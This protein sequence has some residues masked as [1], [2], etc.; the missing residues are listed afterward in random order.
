MKNNKGF[1]L[2]ELLI[3]IAIIG[4]LGVTVVFSVIGL[5]NKTHNNTYE[6][7]LKDLLNA[8]STYS[9]LS[10][11]AFDNGESHPDCS[12]SCSFSLEALVHKGLVDKKIYETRSPIYKA[13]ANFKPSDM[14]YVT[15]INGEKD[16]S[17]RSGGCSEVKLSTIDTYKWEQC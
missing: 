9:Q 12:I 16:I 3:T 2:V 11:K 4:V 1:T 6:G 5:L 7:Q 17:F 8:A 14:F 13:A 10:P 15:R